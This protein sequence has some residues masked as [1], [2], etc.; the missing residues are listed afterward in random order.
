MGD[1]G[2]TLNGDHGGGSPEEVETSIFSLSLKKPTFSTPSDLGISDCGFNTDGKEICISMME[3]LDFAVTISAMLGV[4]FP[5]GSIGR[6]NPLLYSLG[7]G[8]WFQDGTATDDLKDQLEG[9]MQDYVNSLCINAWQVKRYIDVYSGSSVIGFPAEDLLYV[10]DM[11]LQAQEH[12]SHA[13]LDLL[14]SESGTNVSSWPVLMRQA[15]AY[16]K[17]LDGVIDLARSKWTEFDLKLMGVGLS[18]LFVSLLIQLIAVRSLD[19]FCCSFPLPSGHIKASIGS[20]FTLSSVVI[21]AGSFLSNSYILEEGKVAIFFLATAGILELRNSISK[22]K[23][24]SEATS[25]FLLVFIV[26]LSMEYGLSKQAASS[27]GFAST[28]G[29]SLHDSARTYLSLIGPIL[30]MLLLVYMLSKFVTRRSDLGAQ[31]YVVNGAILCYILIIAHWVVESNLLAMPS[32][33]QRIGRISIPRFIYAVGILQLVSIALSEQFLRKK[34]YDNQRVLIHKAV[35]VLSAWSSTILLL[36]GKQGSLVALGAVAG[37]WCIARLGNLSPDIMDGSFYNI[38]HLPLPVT[39]W[40]LL[41]VCLFFCTGHWCAFD[42]LRYGAA[43]IGF[44][45]FILVR[46]AI[47][48]AID[49]FGFSHILPVFGLPVL[50]AYSLPN[51][52]TKQ[53]Q[54]SVL[55]VRLALVYM[56]YGFITALSATF[57]V[58]CVTIHRRHLMVW[59][60]FAPKYVFD[61]LG[62]IVTDTLIC[63]AVLYYI[64]PV[65]DENTE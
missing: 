13:T 26:R 14:S 3:Q 54:A 39:K 15:N 24:L 61:V 20:M 28:L 60:L 7:A 45:E 37:A 29:I 35:N 43:F 52:Q 2:Q 25:S 46:Q 42:G 6:V 58:L 57:T 47:L 10:E 31:T 5:F 63:L 19:K 64:D 34:S 23:F 27:S 12:W 36:A 11:Y 65:E 59:G 18:I 62:L 41:A 51:Q 32:L 53:T 55:F 40:S 33:L 17:F 22:K 38:T 30:A 21:R 4:P 44:D 48:L 9:W 49:T 56:M 16:L 50:V 1:H 8:R